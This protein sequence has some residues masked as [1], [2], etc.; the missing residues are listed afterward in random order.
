MNTVNSLISGHHWGNGFCPLIGDV[1]LLESLTFFDLL[2]PRSSNIDVVIRVI[3]KNFAGIKSIK[4]TFKRTKRK[5]KQHS[6]ALKKYLRGRKYIS[7]QKR[8]RQHSYKLKKHLR[9]RK[10]ISK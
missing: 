7:E 1:R 5:K 10:Y 8:K 9:G 3:W 4:N 2:L 6:H